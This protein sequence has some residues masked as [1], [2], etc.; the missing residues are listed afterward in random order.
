MNFCR[1]R[2][3]TVDAPVWFSGGVRV[4]SCRKNPVFGW[5]SPAC[6]ATNVHRIQVVERPEIEEIRV[7]A[8][9]HARADP[10]REALRPDVVRLE[11]QVPD[12]H[13]N[14]E[15]RIVMKHG[16]RRAER[17]DGARRRARRFPV[18]LALDVE[19]EIGR[20]IEARAAGHE[21]GVA[22]GALAK[23]GRGHDAAVRSEEKPA[24]GRL[25]LGFRR[26]GRGLWRGVPCV[27][28]RLRRRGDFS[29]GRRVR[30]ARF[31]GRRGL[32][33][34]GRRRVGIGSAR[35]W[36]G[37]RVGLRD[38]ERGRGAERRGEE[39]QRG[40]AHA[41]PA[42]PEFGSGS[43]HG[44]HGTPW[45]RPAGRSRRDQIVLS[46]RCHD[47]LRWIQRREARKASAKRAARSRS[48]GPPARPLA[49]R[50]EPTM[51]PWARRIA[52]RLSSV[53]P[54]AT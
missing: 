52:G 8:A 25:L 29:L 54:L 40:A 19:L 28:S 34:R 9:V 18:V 53:T 11:E 17:D 4:V 47:A 21:I 39:G 45:R 37:G 16:R 36:L 44:P 32:L 22:A 24:L 31:G 5:F 7:V 51:R 13:A 26:L 20:L 30:I 12:G 14:I 23:I 43:S 35:C 38:R 48:I 15:I 46:R 2:T 41:A 33:G 6:Q 49:R 1:S 42:R 50:A 3:A 27:G 10:G